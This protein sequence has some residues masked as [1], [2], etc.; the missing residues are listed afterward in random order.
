MIKASFC[1][2]FEPEEIDKAV[3]RLA[4]MGY[5]GIEFW[6]KIIE[7]IPTQRIKSVLNGNGIA[8]SQVCPYF[9]FVSG[10]E[11]WDATIE[12]GKRYI[13]IA[14]ELGST[15]I[16][17]F[18]GPRS[19]IGAGSIASEEQ[20]N[21]AIEGLQVLCDMAAPHGIRF[22]LEC[23]E[24]MLMEDTPT[25]L[26]LLN[27]VGKSNLGANPQVPLKDEDP[28]YSLKQLAPYTIHMHSHNWIE[29]VSAP[30]GTRMTCLEDGVLDYYAI[31]E[32]LIKN[33]FDGYLSI[34]H[35]NHGGKDDSWDTAEREASFFVKLKKHAEK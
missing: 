10:K 6:Q 23:H 18:T 27:G 12:M 22:A 16:R 31:V 14:L 19:G 5:D 4:E 24:G 11:K 9:D 8:C 21:A 25:A 2:V 13:D 29:D 20:W 7:T 32:L 26:R 33:K 28:M 35:A 3:A 30:H 17:V 1:Y 15:L 34:E